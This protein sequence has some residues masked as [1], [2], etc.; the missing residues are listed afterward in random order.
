METTTILAI[1]FEIIGLYILWVIFFKKTEELPNY[2]NGENTAGEMTPK[3]Q[4]SDAAMN[5]TPAQSSPTANADAKDKKNKLEQIK[6]AAPE[7]INS[8]VDNWM[9][10]DKK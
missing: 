9:Q 5:A 2:G 10:E 4:T 7:E 3:Y 6:K 1:L 8:V